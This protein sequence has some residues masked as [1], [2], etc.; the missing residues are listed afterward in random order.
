VVDG[1]ADD[2]EASHAEEFP[3]VDHEVGERDVRR[4]R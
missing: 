2:V 4:L 1:D 3:A